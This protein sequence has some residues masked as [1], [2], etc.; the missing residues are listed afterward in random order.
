M[1]L[2]VFWFRIWT[3][4]DRRVAFNP[5]LSPLGRVSEAVV[6][7]MRPVFFSTPPRLIA[8]MSLAFLIVFR[9]MIFHSIAASSQVEWILNIG[10]EAHRIDVVNAVSCM[11]FSVLSF[12]IFL[13]NLWG[14]SLIYVWFKR[15]SS[16]DHTVDAL[17]QLSRPFSDV[18]NELRPVILLA[19]GMIL[20]F[21]L[22]RLAG[23]MSPI[24]VR[25]ATSLLTLIVASGMSS[26]AGWVHV[27]PII[28]N[29]LMMLIIG[30]WVSMFTSSHGIMLFCREWIDMLLGP[31]R[32][33]PIRIGMLDLTPIVFFLV[34]SFVHQLL[35]RVL[36]NSYQGL[37]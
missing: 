26:L 11:I 9:S 21:F 12:A 27:L 6:N 30:S 18:R 22:S 2:L 24:T 28:M 13:F 25:R 7:F 33:Y 8:A 3:S 4:N 5:Y 31:A 1:V 34:I 15:G 10:F 19:F 37:V 17:Y 14:L 32:R 29:V 35:I 36:F 16:F 20:I 23:E